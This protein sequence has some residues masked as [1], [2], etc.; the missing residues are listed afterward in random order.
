MNA[1]PV[2]TC[3]CRFAHNLPACPACGTPRPS[4]E[5]VAAVVAA[6]PP[7][8]QPVTPVLPAPP[9]ARL[10]PAVLAP[11]PPLPP[12]P[13]LPAKQAK[14]APPTVIEHDRRVKTLKVGKRAKR[15]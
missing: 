14:H 3:V 6:P 1:L 11:P 9:Q 5:V 10:A 2:V 8:P 4:A 7:Q 15:R 12:A 13:V